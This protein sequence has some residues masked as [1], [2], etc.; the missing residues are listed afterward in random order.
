MLH[1]GQLMLRKI[2]HGSARMLTGELFAVADLIVPF[3]FFASFCA[4]GYK[5][6]L[7]VVF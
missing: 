2:V 5:L 1:G 6:D 7:S 4:A 3:S